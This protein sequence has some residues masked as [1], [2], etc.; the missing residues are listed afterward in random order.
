MDLML[1]IIVR[2]ILKGKDREKTAKKKQSM[3]EVAVKLNTYYGEK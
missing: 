1:N 2:R 3:G